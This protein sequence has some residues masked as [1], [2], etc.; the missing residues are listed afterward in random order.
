MQFKYRCP[1]CG[2]NFVVESESADLVQ[3]CTTLP[4]CGEVTLITADN[5]DRV[6]PTTP[7][8]EV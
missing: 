6:H 5:E 2:N 7:Q 1:V 8:P 4:E 3:I